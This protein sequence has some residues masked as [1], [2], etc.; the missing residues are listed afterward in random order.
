MSVSSSLDDD[1][2]ILELVAQAV[3]R[4]LIVVRSDDAGVRG[5]TDSEHLE[6][7]ASHA[8]TL[9]T[10]NRRDFL[11]LHWDY[12]KGMP[13]SGIVIV[14]QHIPRG[15]RV[16]LLLLPCAIASPEDLNTKVVLV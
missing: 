2:G 10:C 9:V 4:G 12:L 7:A 8:L 11:A 14:N 16:R 1:T 6:Y 15:E 13:H 5:K 3:Q